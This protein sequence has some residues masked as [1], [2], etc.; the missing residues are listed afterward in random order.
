MISPPNGN[1]SGPEVG[2]WEIRN[3]KKVLQEVG[4]WFVGKPS[5]IGKVRLARHPSGIAS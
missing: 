5:L 2:F 1:N 4:G 3:G